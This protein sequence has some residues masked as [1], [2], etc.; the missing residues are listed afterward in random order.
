[1]LAWRQIQYDLARTIG[2]YEV[3]NCTGRRINLNPR[4]SNHCTGWI[5]DLDRDLRLRSLLRGELQGKE[6][7]G[8]QA[9]DTRCGHNGRLCH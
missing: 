2:L 9:G 3:P 1:M 6:G 5:N 4:T 7:G 8:E